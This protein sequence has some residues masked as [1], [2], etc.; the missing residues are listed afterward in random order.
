MAVAHRILMWPPAAHHL[1]A[2]RR[3]NGLRFTRWAAAIALFGYLSL[4]PLAVLAFVAFGVALSRFPD[5]RGEVDTALRDSIPLLFGEEAGSS[6]V[7]IAS[8]AEATVSAG[9]VSVLAL[10]VTGL[11]WVD[12]TIEGTRRMLGA[13]H[14][15]RP[16][17]LLRLEDAASLVVV[18]TMLLLAVVVSVGARSAGTWLLGLIGV[19]ANSSAALQLSADIVALLLVWLVVASF[20]SFAWKRPQRRWRPI[21]MASF[22]TAAVLALMSRFAYLVVG[23]TLDNPVYGAL[24]VAAAILLFLY[25]ISIV[26]LYFACW[27]AI[28]EGAPET[29][30]ERAF[31]SRLHDGTVVLPTAE[32]A[33]LDEDDDANG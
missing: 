4:F 8:V 16:F 3:A 12:A 13:L 15:P 26:H 28:A 2:Y 23:R 33:P 10:L 20:Y 32:V 9:V 21:I 6:P 24:A 18:G 14:R 27:V 19:E 5:L 30:E 25:F 7:D 11:G 1:A 17:L 29:S 31:W 22:M